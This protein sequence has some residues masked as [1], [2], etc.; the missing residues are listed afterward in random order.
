MPKVTMTFSLPDERLEYADA[1]HGGEWRDIV[2]ELS[3]LLRNALKYGHEYGTAD[4]ALDTVRTA[5]WNECQ[6]HGLDPWGD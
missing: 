2:F 3:V 4:E 5:L 6:S 1:L